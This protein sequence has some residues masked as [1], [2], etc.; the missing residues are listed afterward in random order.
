M[1]DH[2][3]VVDP[4]QCSPFDPPFDRFCCP[5]KWLA[6]L[7]ESP[8][9]LCKYIM[10]TSKLKIWVIIIWRKKKRNTISRLVVLNFP[11]LLSHV[12]V[13]FVLLNSVVASLSYFFFVRFSKPCVWFFHCSSYALSTLRPMV[14]IGQSLYSPCYSIQVYVAFYYSWSKT[15]NDYTHQ[16]YTYRSPSTLVWKRPP[17][18]CLSP[19]WRNLLPKNRY[20]KEANAINKFRMLTL[21]CPAASSTSNCI[22]SLSN[23][24]LWVYIFSRLGSYSPMNR[25]VM[26]LTTIA[27]GSLLKNNKHHREISDNEY[28]SMVYA[29]RKVRFVKIN[30]FDTSTYT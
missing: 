12:F 17:N 24:V 21:G 15:S 22:S 10:E 20:L 25:L 27:V 2:E 16:N 1:L 23:V 30:T 13:E 5:P 11:K 6:H 3:N 29:I 4:P 26:N 28:S 9:G 18:V 14:S 19:S 7:R 8:V